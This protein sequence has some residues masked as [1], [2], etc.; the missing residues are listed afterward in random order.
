MTRILGNFINNKIPE[1]LTDK[2]QI[3]SLNFFKVIG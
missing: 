3:G 1:F 2:I